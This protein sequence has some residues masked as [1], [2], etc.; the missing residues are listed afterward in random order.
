MAV[1]AGGGG[2]R[3]SDKTPPVLGGS[4]KPLVPGSHPASAC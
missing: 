3:E 4:S 1:V 2:D